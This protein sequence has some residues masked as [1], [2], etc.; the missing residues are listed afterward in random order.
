M[1]GLLIRGKKLV[2]WVHSTTKLLIMRGE[3]NRR[4]LKGKP[5]KPTA[6]E[7]IKLLA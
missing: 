7:I 5:P 1:D 2:N 3:K 4:K 6:W